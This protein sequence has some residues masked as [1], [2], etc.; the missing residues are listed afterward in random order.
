M[1]RRRAHCLR[2]QRHFSEAKGILESL[3]NNADEQ[4]R[5]AILT[6]L[7]L[8]NAGTR[9]L[10]DLVIPEKDVS[11][12]L[13]R[14]ESMQPELEIA[15]Q[16]EGDRTNAAY[17]L[18]VFH[19]AKQKD[20]TTAASLLEASVSAMIRRSA[21]YNVGLLLSQA[22]FYLG[23]ALAESLDSARTTYSAELFQQAISSTFRPPGHLLRRYVEALLV[24]SPED[25]CK[26]AECSVRNLPV[27]NSTLDDLA[28]AEIARRSPELLEVL[29]K[30]A[31]DQ[32]R[33]TKRRFADLAAVLKEAL[34]ARQQ[35]IAE[36]ALGELET[37]ALDGTC[38]DKFLDLLSDEASYDPVWSNSDANW[39]S[40]LV[41]ER[42]GNYQRAAEL[43]RGEFH[44]TVSQSD[45]GSREEAGGDFV[46]DRIIRSP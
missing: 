25:A 28:Y 7:A 22:R 11:A 5:S 13:R 2:L 23:L 38:E 10:M 20:P 34:E 1:Q 36:R 3:A 32:R 40:V 39:S 27:G 43:L 35:A 45:F 26:I 4:N 17:C 42:K 37:I 9:G 41:L 18:G 33:P 15:H 8:V 21:D 46:A 24:S 16:A 19:L 31:T 44:R 30:W 12:F 6:D 14:L 29:Y